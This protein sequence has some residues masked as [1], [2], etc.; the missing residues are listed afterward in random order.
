MIF[1][2][3]QACSWTGGISQDSTVK[4]DLKKDKSSI[5]FTN[6]KVRLIGRFDLSREGRARFTWPGSS[7]EFRFEGTAAGIGI[8]GNDRVRFL[9]TVDGHDKELWVTQGEDVYQ[10]ASGLKAGK[11]SVRVTRLSES[12]TGV[13]AFTSGPIVQGKMLMPPD[14]PGRRLLVLGD[15]I[16]AG[17]G[18]EGES[19]TCSYSPET[20]NPL[21]AYAALAA[22]TLE[23]DLHIIAWSGIGVWRSYGEKSP[24]NPTITDRYPLALADSFDSRWNPAGFPPDAILVAIGTNDYWDGESPGYRDGMDRLLS[25]LRS[26]YPETP[27][28]LIV[29]PMLTGAPREQ[30]KSVLNSFAGPSVTVLDLGRIEASDGYGCDYH[31]N[32]K[33]QSRMAGVLVER[34]GD[35]L[36]WR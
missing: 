10:L 22:T 36:G 13:T 23:A 18:V 31:P 19:E 34:L 14:P 1:A 20:S 7:L 26:D 6:E 28:Y 27:V 30:Q 33:T 12:F 8:A 35:D 29:S 15:S 25:A 24:Q 32:T 3:T 4:A 11:H 5:G 9:V 16:T 17:Y 21:K 2:I